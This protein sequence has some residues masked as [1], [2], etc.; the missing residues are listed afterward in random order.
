MTKI[1]LVRHGHVEGIRPARFRGREDL[2]L[3]RRGQAEALAVAQR[4]ASKWQPERVYTSPLSRCVATGAAIAS[5]CR[6]EGESIEALNDIDYGAWRMKSH[7]EMATKDPMLQATWFD[8][9]HLMRF[10][11][12]DSLQDLAARAA[13]AVRF[14][15]ERHPSRTVVLVSHDS[16]NRALLL[17]LADLPLSAYWRLTQEPCC[18]NEIEISRNRIRVLAINETA[19]LDGIEPT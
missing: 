19:H 1:L 7:E 18:I 3:T 10:P 2:P 14:V 11:G 13:D 17:Q 5:A 15:I 4:I 9:P 16:V 12:G 6:I 8:T